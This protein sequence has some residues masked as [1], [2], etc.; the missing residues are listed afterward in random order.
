ML[1]L[2]LKQNRRKGFTLI[3]LI[4]VI[5]IIAIMTA[6]AIPVITSGDTRGEKGN[7]YAKSYYYAMQDI[8]INY[9]RNGGFGFLNGS[10]VLTNLTNSADRQNYT[11]AL[12][13]LMFVAAVTNGE[14]SDVKAYIGTSDGFNGV[15]GDMV[16]M[17]LNTSVSPGD[18]SDT[19]N[20]AKANDATLYTDIS[21]KLS[22]KMSLDIDDGFLY[23]MVD[24]YFRT[25]YAYWCEADHA[26]LFAQVDKTKQ[27]ASNIVG[28]YV[29][30]AFPVER[31]IMLD[32]GNLFDDT[33]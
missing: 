11:T 18:A 33:L 3:E 31:S 20:R 15:S 25:E 28:A 17:G 24:P 8:M 16:E 26:Q 12:I 5:T 4:V 29:Y 30:G 22:N 19:E 1:S 2:F 21:R 14:I 9:E 32:G 7:S 6:I 13:D 27:T 23:V 10:G